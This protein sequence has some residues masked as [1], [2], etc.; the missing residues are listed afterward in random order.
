MVSLQ[1]HMDALNDETVVIT[2]EGNDSF[3]TEDIQAKGMDDHLQP[4]EEFLRIKGIA[5]D[6]REAGQMVVVLVIVR[7]FKKVR[8]RD[9]HP[10]FSFVI[11]AARYAPSSRGAEW[12][13][14]GLR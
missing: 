14:Q 8:E 3:Q 9:E 4:G 1:Q 12:D 11:A 10:T 7:L 6:K 5:L 2:G 13:G